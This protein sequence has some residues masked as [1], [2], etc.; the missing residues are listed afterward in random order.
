MLG[1]SS[2][3]FFV[4]VRGAESGWYIYHIAVDFDEGRT[5]SLWTE[6]NEVGIVHDSGEIVTGSDISAGAGRLLVAAFLASLR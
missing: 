5:P 3:T 4:P 2:M 1:D 6:P